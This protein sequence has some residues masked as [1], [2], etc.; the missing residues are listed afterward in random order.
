MMRS[1][2]HKPYIITEYLRDL[3]HRAYRPILLSYGPQVSYT[4]II[5]G[6]GSGEI[7]DNKSL[8]GLSH[9]Q[10]RYKET[11]FIFISFELTTSYVIWF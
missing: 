2:H 8:L 3:V 7:V 5:H 6:D 11:Y 4:Q 10:S 1:T 9:I